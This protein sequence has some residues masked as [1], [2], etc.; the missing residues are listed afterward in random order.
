MLNVSEEN[1]VLCRHF[2]KLIQRNPAVNGMLLGAKPDGFHG[3][4]LKQVYMMILSPTFFGV[5]FAV[6]STEGLAK[7]SIMNF[8][9]VIAHVLLMPFAYKYTDGLRDVY[10]EKLGPEEV[11]RVNFAKAGGQGELRAI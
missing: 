6:K 10:F 3:Y 4:E 5:L 1:V 8:V 9:F 7:M 11:W 2:F